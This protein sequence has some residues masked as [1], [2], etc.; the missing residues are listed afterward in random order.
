MKHLLTAFC[1]ALTFVISAFGQTELPLKTD[2]YFEGIYQNAGTPLEQFTDKR[3]TVEYK[4]PERGTVEA[5]LTLNPISPLLARSVE[6]T[7]SDNPDYPRVK[8][9]LGSIKYKSTSKYNWFTAIFNFAVG[10]T[11]YQGGFSE[12]GDHSAKSAVLRMPEEIRVPLTRTTHAI[13][14]FEPQIFLN[15]EGVFPI[16][17]SVRIESSEQRRTRRR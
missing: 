3:K 8:F 13:L 16:E 14:T 15:A 7:T 4:D 2:L 17:C 5:A 12:F 6:L 11:I 1:I 10:D 9:V